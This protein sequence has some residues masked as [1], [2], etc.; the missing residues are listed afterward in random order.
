MKTRL[1]GRLLS[2]DAVVKLGLITATAVGT[3]IVV[4]ALGLHFPLRDIV[5]PL[6]LTAVLWAVARYYLG[7]GVQKFVLCTS[8]L[9]YLVMFCAS[10]VVLMYALAATRRPLIDE[11]LLRVDHR[12]GFQLPELLAWMKSHPL[13]DRVLAVAYDTLLPQTILVIAV[14][15]FRADNDAL[16]KFILRFMVCAL[17]TVILFCLLPALGPFAAAGSSPNATQIRTLEQLQ[18]MR[19]G[20]RTTVTWRDA[21]GLIT[22]PSFHTI[23]AILM[24]LAYRRHRIQFAFFGALNA[25]VIVS[26]L[27]TGWH[28]LSDVLGGVV[29]C[30]LVLT[31]LRPLEKWVYAPPTTG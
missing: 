4:S 10:F 20:A 19:S 27:T 26:T 9:A 3:A 24:A 15:G 6:L 7:R 18:A 1:V 17:V 23:W 14:L 22:F 29:A 30:F 21:E 13:L 28:Y 5:R 11:Q 12:L 2:R 16:R 31:S 25:L 8:S